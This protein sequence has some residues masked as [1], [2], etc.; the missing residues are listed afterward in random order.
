MSETITKNLYKDLSVEDVFFYLDYVDGNFYWKNPTS[1]R[2]KKGGLAQVFGQRYFHLSINNKRYMKHKLVFFIHHGYAP[3]I[4]DHIDGNTLNNNI[5]NLREAD[6]FQNRWNA[7]VRKQSSIGL[8]GVTYHPQTKKFRA[9][10]SC[11]YKIYSL[12][13]YKTK[14]EAHQAYCKASL[15]LHKEFGRF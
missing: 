9:R 13:L 7:K 2:V 14:E 6:K 3:K 1:R 12:G 15:E 5:Q 11:K 4:I 8:K 10:I